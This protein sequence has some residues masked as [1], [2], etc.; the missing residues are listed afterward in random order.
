[1]PTVGP[2]APSQKL[3]NRQTSIWGYWA[4]QW[5]P[6]AS[7]EAWT[8]NKQTPN[9]FHSAGILAYALELGRIK[10]T[11]TTTNPWT[12]VSSPKFF[13]CHHHWSLWANHAITLLFVTHDAMA[14]INVTIFTESRPL[15]AKSKIL[16]FFFTQFEIWLITCRFLRQKL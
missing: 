3:L 5:L 6:V 1:M 4:V 9:Q 11:R 13:S 7:D 15:A 16:L 2:I 8:R 14:S 10:L 12:Q